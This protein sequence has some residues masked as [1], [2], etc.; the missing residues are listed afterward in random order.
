MI[1]IPFISRRR[2][3]YNH[4][5]IIALSLLAAI[6]LASVF[7]GM[8]WYIFG[9]KNPLAAHTYTQPRTL[10]VAPQYRLGSLI[11]DKILK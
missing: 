8:Y 4:W 10:Y 1:Q 3:H 5:K 9:A 2:R 11:V 7:L 6:F